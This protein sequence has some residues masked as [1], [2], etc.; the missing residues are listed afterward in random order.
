M[1]KIQSIMFLIWK[2]NTMK[3]LILVFFVIGTVMVFF[4]CQEESALA[5]ELDQINQVTNSLA[6]PL[7]NLIGTM[8]LTFNFV[9]PVWVG[10]ITFEG[11][12]TYDMRFFSLT[13]PRDYSQA[14][15]FKEIFEIYDGD[16]I[17][18]RGQVAGVTTLANNPPD[19][20]SKYRMNGKIDEATGPFEDWPG[21]PPEHP[22]Q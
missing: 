19:E 5:P 17:Y 11:I 2:E 14:S 7:P 1:N 21:H 13:L 12:G 16:I 22:I 20:P 15:P 18:L 9:N 4:G 6:K 10:T 8:D 3:K